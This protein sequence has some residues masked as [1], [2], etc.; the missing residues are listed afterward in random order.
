MDHSSCN[1]SI[2]NCVKL[3]GLIV[4][5]TTFMQQE[6][7]EQVNIMCYFDAITFL[8][9]SLLVAMGTD[10][11]SYYHHQDCILLLLTDI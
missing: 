4:D 10:L 7:F 8:A 11:G 9:A 3:G 5:I 6:L 2:S 1:Y